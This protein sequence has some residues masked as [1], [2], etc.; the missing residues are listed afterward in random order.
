MLLKKK[1]APNPKSKP[2]PS[3][4][5][6]PTAITIYTDGSLIR[7]NNQCWAGYG[8]YIPSLNLKL[9]SPLPPPKTNNRGE[10]LAIITALEQCPPEKPIHL[11]TDSKYSLLICQ[12]TGLKYQKQN[13]KTSDGEVL[14]SDLIRRVLKLLP[15]Y[16]IKF[17]H[18]RSHTGLDDIHSQGNEIA[19]KLAVQG[20]LTDLRQSYSNPGECPISFGK[21]SGCLVQDLPP[22]YLTWIQNNKQFQEQCRQDSLKSIDLDMIFAFLKQQENRS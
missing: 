7:K 16:Q 12:G 1:P 4:N 8:V 19:D 15:D 5:L 3:P 20:S 22:S 14:N 13:F 9:S 10:L 18:I 11:Y 2:K 21:H 17:H 6:D